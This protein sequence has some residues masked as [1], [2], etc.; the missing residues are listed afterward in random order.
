M[1]S[2][3]Y[4]DLL[5]LRPSIGCYACQQRYD[6]FANTQEKRSSPSMI[7]IPSLLERKESTAIIS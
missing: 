7:V 6:I 2:K 3:F 1:N 4:S 5:M